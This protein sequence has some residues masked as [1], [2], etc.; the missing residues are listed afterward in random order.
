M[1]LKVKNQPSLGGQE[2]LQR[3][4]IAQFIFVLASSVVIPVIF[5]VLQSHSLVGAET[6]EK[7]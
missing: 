1:V 7:E 6:Q 5:Q 4:L 2:L 3:F